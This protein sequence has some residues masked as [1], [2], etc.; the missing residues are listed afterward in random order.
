MLFGAA[1]A[2]AVDRLFATHLLDS[3]AAGRSSLR[4]AASPVPVAV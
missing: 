4:P 3:W 2:L 1:A